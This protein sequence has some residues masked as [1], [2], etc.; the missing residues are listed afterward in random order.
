VMAAARISKK[1]VDFIVGWVGV[2]KE[3]PAEVGL[4]QL[5]RR[6]GTATKGWQVAEVQFEG[7]SY[8]LGLR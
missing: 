7:C 4:A 5:Q 6:N 1:L 3:T 8:G 2:I